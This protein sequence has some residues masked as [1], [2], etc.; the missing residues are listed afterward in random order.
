MAR[1]PI[2]PPDFVARFTGDDGKATLDFQS[3]I[4]A[5]TRR[6]NELSPIFGTGSPEGSVVANECQWY[7][8]TAEA[9]GGGIYIKESGS[10]DTGWVKRS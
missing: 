1:E 10:G 6:V 2:V 3:Y 8:D 5:L 9:A 7:V 4:D